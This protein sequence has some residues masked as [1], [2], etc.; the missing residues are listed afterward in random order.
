MIPFACAA[1]T[2]A[3]NSANCVLLREVPSTGPKFAVKSVEAMGE[4]REVMLEKVVER[5]G[6]GAS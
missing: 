1:T 6:M 2:C 5:K 3:L 4:T